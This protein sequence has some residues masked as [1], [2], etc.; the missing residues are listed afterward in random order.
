VCLPIEVLS[1]W[2]RPGRS[3]GLVEFDAD[4]SKIAV[5]VES[6]VESRK[7]YDEPYRIYWDLYPAT[8]VQL[9]NLADLQE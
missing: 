6:K 3:V 2:L 7:F 5:T 9:H 1:P 8:C 4:W